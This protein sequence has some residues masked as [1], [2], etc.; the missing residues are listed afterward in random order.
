MALTSNFSWSKPTVGGSA[1]SWGT[2]LNTVFDAIDTDVQAVK[3]TADAAMPKAGGV[4]TAEIEILTER[5]ATVNA[6][7]LSGAV[8]F[9]L[10]VAEYHFGTVTGNITGFTFNNL[11][12]SGKVE[13]FTLELLNGGNFTVSW[14]ATIKW[15]GAV[16]PT[17]QVAGTD[18]MVFWTRDGGTTIRA[19]HSYSRAT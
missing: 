8:T 9:D 16:D 7:N 1:G 17:L 2:E 12:A 13:F 10:N 19:S 11:A 15:D 6:G 18:V 4:F 3:V 14:P 5:L